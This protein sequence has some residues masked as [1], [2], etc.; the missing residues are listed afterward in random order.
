[1]LDRAVTLNQD[2]AIPIDDEIVNSRLGIFRDRH[3][4]HHTRLAI[5]R[6][7][8]TTTRIRMMC[9]KVIAILLYVLDAGWI[10][11]QLPRF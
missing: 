8:N 3:Q 11:Y 7:S 2:C 10:G 6:A 4:I 5:A 9:S 1:M